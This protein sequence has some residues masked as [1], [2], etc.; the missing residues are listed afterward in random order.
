MWDPLQLWLYQTEG[1]ADGLVRAQLIHLTPV[2]LAVVFGAG[3]VTSL[4]PC[5][6]SMLP[7]TVGYIGGYSETQQ[8]WQATVQSIWFA[9]GLAVTLS[10]LGLSAALL[11]RIYGQVGNFWPLL[12]GGVAIAMG[13]NLLEILPLQ[14]PNWLADKEI[15]QQWPTAL[16]S[17]LLGLTFGLIASPCSTPVLVALL[18][19]VSTSGN[20]TLGGGLL[21]VY[22]LGL[23]SPL[24]VA[25]T[26]TGLL[27][28]LLSARSW[29][30]WL[31]YGS[32]GL[33]VGFGTLS[34]LTQ[35]A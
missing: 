19:W 2:S 18:G 25:G 8:R 10:A 4:S 6:L 20:P 16:R 28:Q 7:I 23:V 30:R 11:G 13:L 24:I 31:T 33:L 21:L 12:M 32:G 3:L 26:F 35:L 9:L 29:S 27:K 15:P 17:V 22:A 34:I 1:W 5:M 14:F